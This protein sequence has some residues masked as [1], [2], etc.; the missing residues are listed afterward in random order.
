M[1]FLNK[2][3]SFIEKISVKAATYIFIILTFFIAG[4]N[5][6]ITTYFDNKTYL[7]YCLYKYDNFMLIV[8]SATFLILV[9]IYAV[10]KINFE[11]VNLVNLLMIYTVFFGIIWMSISDTYPVADSACI[12]AVVSEFLHGNYDNLFNETSYISAYPYQLGMVFLIEMIYRVIGEDRYYFLMLLNV[13]SIC[14]VFYFLYKISK[15]IF[16]E[17]KISRITLLLLFGCFPA[18][19]YVTYVYGT[20]YGLAFSVIGIYA[21]I[22]YCNTNKLRY[23]FISA[24]SIGISIVLK[25]NYSIVL[26]AAIIILILKFCNMKKLIPLI[27][28]V[29]LV[30][31][32]MILNSLVNSYYEKQSGSKI[33]DGAPKLLWIAMGLQNGD[34]AEGWYNGFNWLTFV[35]Y[36]DSKDS[37][38]IAKNSIKESLNSFKE[39]P[40]HAVKFFYKKIISQWSEPTYQSI[41]S[42]HYQQQNVH[43]LS[44]V[45]KSIYAGVL[46]KIILFYMNIYNFI[47]WGCTFIFFILKRKDINFKQLLC[48]IVVIGGFLFHI[49]WEGKSM[50]IF[51]YFMLV[52]PYSAAGIFEISN[53]TLNVY[54]KLRLKFVKE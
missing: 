13:L 23:I 10:K 27:M 49:I 33:S 34:A 24:I 2:I 45:G 40:K 38:I 41:F 11:K 7:E 4:I 6:F 39:N 5:L 16:E 37:E 3:L 18:L 1:L 9:I 32:P 20:I 17:E 51:P 53:F 46:N 19:F 15:E 54:S 50:Y 42:S 30:I 21:V 22:R 14:I 48:A 26:I 36:P 47:I 12:F 28:I 52:I 43:E 31:T 8:I 25:S 44:W 29:F 35:D